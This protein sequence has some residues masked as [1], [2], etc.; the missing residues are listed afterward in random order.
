M[1][2]VEFDV[3]VGDGVSIGGLTAF[4]LT[5]LK[6]DGLPYLT[7][8]EA[9]ERGLIEVGELDPVVSEN[10]NVP[11]TRNLSGPGPSRLPS[12][13]C[14]G[15]EQEVLDH[16]LVVNERHLERILRSYA[17]HYNGHRPH[18]GLSQEIPEPE[19]TARP[20]A[21][22]G[23]SDSRYRQVRDHRIRIRRYDRLGGLIHE[24]K[25]AG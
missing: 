1:K 21:I 4:P 14:E 17:R 24:Y 13:R 9:C 22:Q 8:P 2:V 12:S 11:A 7:G 20:L 6:V 25:C 23:A 15:E 5:T 3:Q 18:Q 10:V 16:L 19:R